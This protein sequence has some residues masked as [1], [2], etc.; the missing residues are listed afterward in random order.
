M[1]DNNFAGAGNVRDLVPQT[2]DN[3]LPPPGSPDIEIARAARI[4]P[5][6]DIARERLDIPSEALVPYGHH[7]AKLSLEFVKSLK[8]RALGKLVLVT[9]I[10][11]T[12]AGEGKTTTSVGLN[13]GLNAIGVKSSAC[14][15]EPS[16]GPCFGM[17]GGA[18]GGGRAQV[19][20]MD[21][22]NLHFNGDFHAITAAHSL[23][24]AVLDN[25]IHWGNELDIDPRRISWKRVVDMNDRALRKITIG[26]GGPA[27]G[28]PREDGFNI[29]VASEIMAILCLAE[30]LHDL[31]MR[32]G[33][34]VVAQRRDKSPVTVNDLDV[35][36][37]MAVL[38]KD[39]LAPNMVQSLEHNPVF[40]HGGPFANIAHG[41]NSV[42]ATRAALALNDVVITEA[43]F[44][45]DL[46]AEKFLNIKCRQSGLRPDAVVLVAT[47]RA[48][49]MHGGVSKADLATPNPEAVVA[50]I[51]N[52]ERHI[53]NLQGFGLNPIVAINHFALDTPEEIAVVR[54]ACKKLNVE[55]VESKHWEK[56]SAGSTDLARAVQNQLN[57]PSSKITLTYEDN[58]SLVDKLRAIAT[59]IYRAADI[60]IAPAALRKLQ[61]F[62]D[63]GYG[64]LP[65]C[66]AKTQY[67]FSIDQEAKGAPTGH[68]LFVGDVSLSAGAGF[69][70]A[71]CGNIMT[72]P[73]LPRKP[74]ALDIGFDKDGQIVGLS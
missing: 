67:S 65:V 13:D 31:Q 35:A 28:V 38:L 37:A 23:L 49:K 53:E 7:K 50:G 2:Q 21:D 36:G 55:A 42:I 5:I 64:H 62:S 26:L 3:T 72:M 58:I 22:I 60:E 39:A 17:K 11:P 71:V 40:I 52:L 10:T 30:D 41:C 19:I 43:G 56:G 12:P 18:A 73:G 57:Q 25:H 51:S 1:H 44:G 45:A 47:I 68:T 14:L 24:S 15:R 63:M 4:Y 8:D 61:E 29:T 32:L 74:A 34:I 16:L 33:R 69:I 9:A 59:K 70:V 6:M 20:P 27:Y 46:G 66:V 48:L 54:S